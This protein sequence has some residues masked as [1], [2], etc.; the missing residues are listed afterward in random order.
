MFREKIK[1]FSADI[2]STRLQNQSD[3]SHAVSQLDFF[4]KYTGCHVAAIKSLFSRPKMK[5]KY[6]CRENSVCR[7]LIQFSDSFH[8]RF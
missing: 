1:T 4:Q 2:C 5:R 3:T 6:L 7:L 8:A